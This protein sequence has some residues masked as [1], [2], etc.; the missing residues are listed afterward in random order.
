MSATERLT[1]SLNTRINAA[2]Q[3]D[4]FDFNSYAVFNGVP[5]GAN[6]D[7]I[8]SLFDA[9]TDA[10]AD[11]AAYFDTAKVD[12]GSP[13]V[14]NFLKAHVGFEAD[15][16][17]TLI[18][19]ADDGSPGA[20][21]LSNSFI[22]NQQ[23]GNLVDLDRSI[24]GRY[25]QLRIENVNGSDFSLDSIMLLPPKMV[26]VALFAGALGL[27]MRHD[28]A[29]VKFDPET[30]VQELP[31]AVN[32]DVEDSGRVT[33]RKGFT[34]KRA[35][36]AHSLFSYAGHC[37]FCSG[38]SLYQLRPDYSARSLGYGLTSGLRMSHAPVGTDIF[39]C[40]GV[41]N[42]VIDLLRGSVK[43][44]R[45]GAY[46]GPPLA[47]QIHPP[48]VGHLVDVF[49]GRVLLAV[50]NALLHSLPF[51]PYWFAPQR[52]A[53][54]FGSTLTLMQ[55][56]QDGVW[57]SDEH[58]AWFLAGPDPDQW[59]MV[60]K[61]PY[62]A[63]AGTQAAVDASMVGELAQRG[64]DGKAVMWASREG[65]CVGAAGGVFLNLTQDT[66]CLPE[67]AT[68]AGIWRNGRYAVSLNP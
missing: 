3:Y 4:G 10:G 60:M 6:E 61:A 53:V 44:W 17:L 57:V 27:N 25:F 2:S 45:G 7:G 34:L 40:N 46:V 11:I 30:G 55:S 26:P 29:R 65:V 50:D 43:A 39:H 18:M 67:A 33:R 13:Y 16:D 31:E 28:P 59:G 21:T 68:G 51:A 5:L 64:I 32:V 35:G 19:R 36:A 23:H 66:V 48:P 37:F 52:N 47:Y 8:Y 38:D 42:G 41:Q 63:V 54:R 62:P 58:A 22:L 20:K 15:G 1:L 12:W 56:V 24:R 9:Q 49:G 14:K